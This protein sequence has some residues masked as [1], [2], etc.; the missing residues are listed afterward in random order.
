MAL[1]LK[2][3]RHQIIV[4]TGATSGI[5]L[6][7]ARMAARRG[8]RLVLAARREDA[9]IELE[10]ELSNGRHRAVTVT[11]D[12][13]KPADVQRISR[14]ARQMFGGFDTWVNNAGVS[15]YGR[16][17]DEPIDDMR[18][19]FETNFWGLVY[20]SMEAARYFREHDQP[21]SIINVGSTLSD[22]AL[23]LQGMYSASKHAVKAFTDA[24]RM[25]VEMDGIP[26]AVTLIQPGAIATP[27]PQHAKNYMETEPT[28]PPPIYAPETVAQAIL[29]C[30]E[31]R[32]RNVY[33]GA[34]GKGIGMLGYY[35]PR[36]ADLLMETLFARQQQ[37]NRPPARPR[38]EN[39]LDRPSGNLQERGDYQGHVSESSLYT[40]ASL[41]PMLTGAALVGAGLALKTLWPSRTT[42]ERRQS[43]RRTQRD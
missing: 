12:V 23:V 15:I 13:G 33:V 18:R 38:G 27:Y 3:L 26:I 11:A 6:T 2:P 20:G 9:L 17:L 34:G 8:A 14:I 7:T 41:H 4:I 16:L 19:L 10:R 43:P 1:R 35:A 40:T 28:N 31:N 39:A 36:L 24:L 22:R 21:G 42:S 32:E 25:E 29:H 37:T 30:A 5:G